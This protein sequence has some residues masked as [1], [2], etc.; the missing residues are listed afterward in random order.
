VVSCTARTKAKNSKTKAPRLRKT[1]S[2]NA[3]V[4]DR[5]GKQRS[6]AQLPVELI[7]FFVRFILMSQLRQLRSQDRRQSSER[8]DEEKIYCMRRGYI[9]TRHNVC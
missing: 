8:S 2:S 6:V 1:V 4:Q 9:I 5:P 3:F 7:H